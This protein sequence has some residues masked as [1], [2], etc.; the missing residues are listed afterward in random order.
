M[1]AEQVC[2][3]LARTLAAADVSCE[4]RTLDNVHGEIMVAG[5]T[6]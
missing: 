4:Y 3:D 6:S 2:I 1:K 5:S